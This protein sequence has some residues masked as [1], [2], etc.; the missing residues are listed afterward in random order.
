MD[1]PAA[2]DLGEHQTA[3]TVLR[4]GVDREPAAAAGVEHRQARLVGTVIGGP[5]RI[6]RVALAG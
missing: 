4:I 2:L 3:E 1:G 6:S 5:G